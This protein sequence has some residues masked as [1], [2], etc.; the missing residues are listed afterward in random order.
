MILY[1]KDI[2]SDTYTNPAGFQLYSSLNK[3]LDEN[4]VV[5]QISFQ[6]VTGFSTSFLN[7]S[8]G[9]IVEE[10]GAD[11]LKRIKPINIKVSQSQLLKNYFSNELAMLRK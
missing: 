9:A 5:I 7:S 8:L 1:I 3:A 6:D 11:I 10:K 2:V 4:N